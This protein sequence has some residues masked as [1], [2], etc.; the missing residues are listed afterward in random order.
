MGRTRQPY[1]IALAIPWVLVGLLALSSSDARGAGL[2]LQAGS[3]LEQVPTVPS[4]GA[5]GGRFGEGIALSA[6]GR[7]AIVGAPAEGGAGSAW[8]YARTGPN[9]IR[10]GPAL[11]GLGSPEPCIPEG[12]GEAEAC[13]Y[14]LAVALSGDGNTALIG[15][16]AAN[17]GLGAARIYTRSGSTWEEGPEL[18]GSAEIGS[19][20]FGR[21]VA[22]SGDGT[23][24]L[25]G[26]AYDDHGIGAAWLFTR[27]SSGWTPGP[28]LHGGEEGG[29]GYFGRA[30][31]LSSDGATA[32]IGGPLDSRGAGA[33][34]VFG[35]SGA[36]WEQQGPKL[37]PAAA[38]E[39]E[40][41]GHSVALSGDGST[42]LVGAPHYGRNVGA[43][44]VFE[45][46][47]GSWSQQGQPLRATSPSGLSRMG[48]SVALS[49]SGDLALIGGSSDSRGDGAA[50]E[51]A[52]TA[53]SWSELASTAIGAEMNPHA[54]L[55]ASVAVS[56]DATTAL[57]GG[58]SF[59][60]EAGGV[61]SLRENLAIAP[62]VDT[63]EPADGPIKGG[64]S[65]RILGSGFLPGATVTIGNAA[66]EVEVLSETE[67]NA[68]TSAAP[69]G[70][71]EVVVDDAEGVSSAGPSFTFKNPPPQEPPPQKEGPP[72]GTVTTT[73]PSPPA[74]S[75][76]LGEI[77]AK[78]PLAQLGRSGNLAP[79]TGHVLVKVPGAS[80]FAP[81]SA[82][83]QVPFGTIVDATNG[84]VTV[85][86]IG[87]TGKVQSV[88]FYGGAFK[89]LQKRNGQVIA[90][91][92]GGDFSVCPT[93]RERAHRALA[94]TTATARRHIVRK[95]WASGH[96]S[97][98]TKGNYATGAVL[99]TRWLTV[100]RC[101][102]TLIF[103]ATDLVAVTNLVNHR[104]RRVKAHHSYFAAAP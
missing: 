37:T 92:S 53:G 59:E 19:G 23:T 75:G 43:A 26:G 96:G 68:T 62:T 71:S 40:H 35:R 47:E 22:L 7:T 103:V 17:A 8:I 38:A 30:V 83:R 49:G 5:P 10:Q 42:A 65:V 48:I 25:V 21:S 79:V 76:I 28:V 60:D 3:L 69:A 97:Y 44:F 89:L 41:F 88:D 104:H 31:A 16:P 85:T 77:A 64:T 91:L 9:W 32:L 82:I 74:S 86:T 66:V 33:I 50:W 56:A 57:V 94:A 61:W 95:L 98:S 12:G 4:P 84:K 90:V 29:A 24:A 100:D 72:T 67:I 39:A 87:A 52:R 14:G 81:L 18:T 101:D 63:I 34:W 1:G 80:A 20:H 13:R 15:A 78:L 2:R 70:S 102:G 93:A 55:G 58:P 46:S 6:H 54:H 27:T 11:P 99:G 73:T 45:R 51:F 36:E